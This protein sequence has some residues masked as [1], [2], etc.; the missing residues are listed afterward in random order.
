MLFKMPTQY[1]IL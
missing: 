1:N